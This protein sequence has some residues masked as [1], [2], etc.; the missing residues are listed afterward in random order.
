MIRIGAPFH[1]PRSDSDR[2][3]DLNSSICL[4]KWKCTNYH[5]IAY[6][7]CL[8]SSHVITENQKDLKF[9]VRFLIHYTYCT[10]VLIY[11]C[12]NI[13][14][15]F[16][17]NTNPGADWQNR[18][19]N[20]LQVTLHGF[21]ASSFALESTVISYHLFESVWTPSSVL[22]LGKEPFSRRQGATHIRVL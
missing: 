1:G 4:W 19:G 16:A 5:F 20:V 7:F 13:M 6:I 12:N 15:Y 21:Q 18:V 9:D 2:G 8:S 11:S 10:I 22:N 14:Y 3:G 17:N